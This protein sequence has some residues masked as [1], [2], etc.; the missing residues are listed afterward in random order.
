MDSIEGHVEPFLSGI[1]LQYDHA[2][3]I[4]FSSF[5]SQVLL[6]HFS[7]VSLLVRFIGGP[8]LT[9]DFEENPSPKVY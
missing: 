6:V 3:P 8:V 4:C 2:N 5:V 7:A 9:L 1:S